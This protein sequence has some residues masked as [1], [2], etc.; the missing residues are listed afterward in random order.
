[1]TSEHAESKKMPDNHL[2]TFRKIVQNESILEVVPSLEGIDPSFE[3]LVQQFGDKMSIYYGTGICTPKELS[4]GLPFDIL[5]MM[6][7]SEK[8]R[9]TLGLGSVIHHIADTHA[10]TNT[11]LNSAEVDQTAK[12]TYE[13]IC[14]TS[15]NLNLPNI[16][17]ILSSTFDNTDEYL[18]ILQSIPEQRHDYIRREVADM[19]WYRQNSNMYI[20]IGWI[21]QATEVELG[22]DERVYDRTYKKEVGQPVSFIYAKAGRTLD[23]RRPKASPYISIPGENRILLNKDEMVQTKLEA[24]EKQWNDPKIGG[25][26]KY[27]MGIIRLYEDVIEPLDKSLSIDQ[28]VQAIIEKA[29]L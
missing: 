25:A 28:K 6:L 12:I 21:I 23:P 4:V 18:F 10:K 29:T 14:R 8:L 15:A 3:S 27:L 7:F 16:H 13:K 1:M 20:K 24:A 26:R 2:S 9:R 19:E 11:H 5:A 17:P 22:S